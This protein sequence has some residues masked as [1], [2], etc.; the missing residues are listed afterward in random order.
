MLFI[1]LDSAKHVCNLRSPDFWVVLSTAC[2][3]EDKTFVGVRDQA[4]VDWEVAAFVLEWF[5]GCRGERG[6]TAADHKAF[7]AG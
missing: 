6:I 1:I 4:A 5:T 7:V 2:F 3:P